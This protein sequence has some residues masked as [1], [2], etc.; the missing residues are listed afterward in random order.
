MADEEIRQFSAWLKASTER[1]EAL[2]QRLVELCESP[3]GL[4]KLRPV[5]VVEY[6]CA[7]R[8]CLLLVVW[9]TPDGFMFY[10]PSYRLAADV[11]AQSSTPSGRA[12]N[13]I[14]GE[15]AWKPQAGLLDGRY[16]G[17]PNG[18]GLT[19]QCGHVRRIAPGDEL[20]DYAEAATP[21]A[22]RRE[23]L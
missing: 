8:R 21:G 22:P 2:R 5:T 10:Q 9:R 17:L 4:K 19:L 11:N 15:R 7:A 12:R 18:G 23:F 14:D 16:R 13:T 6:R 3:G 1:S 20:L